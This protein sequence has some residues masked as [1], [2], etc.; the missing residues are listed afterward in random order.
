MGDGY[1]RFQATAI[2]AL[3]EATEAFLVGHLE[4]I[5]IFHINI[6]SN[7]Y[8]FRLQHER[9][10]RKAG[11]YSGERLTLGTEIYGEVRSLNT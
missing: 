7:A 8:R 2:G 4:G 3:Q 9:Y 6:L 11:Y 1:F 10:S 5:H